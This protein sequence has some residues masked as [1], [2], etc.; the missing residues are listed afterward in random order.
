M[1]GV[2]CCLHRPI[3]QTLRNYFLLLLLPTIVRGTS[4]HD[5]SDGVSFV[6]QYCLYLS[7]LGF[8]DIFSSVTNAC[9]AGDG[10]SLARSWLVQ[11]HISSRWVTKH[12]AVT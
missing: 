6:I 4:S 2:S 3:S 12:T 1:I 11:L 5:I 10:G 8:M 7:D 9:A